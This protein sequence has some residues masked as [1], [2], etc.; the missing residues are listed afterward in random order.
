MVLRLYE[1]EKGRPRGQLRRSDEGEA[2]DRVAKVVGMTGRNLQRYFRLLLAPLE[3]QNAV[4]DGRLALVV[5]ERVSS[6]SKQQ[7]AQ[8]AER[9]RGGEEVKDVVSGYVASHN[10]RH[11]HATAGF[12]SFRK[13]LEAAL[14]DLEDRPDD[15]YR[16]EINESLPLLERGKRLLTALIREGKKKFVDISGLAEELKDMGSKCDGEN[17]FGEDE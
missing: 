16:R 10:G 2:R 13:H 8:I 7:Q 14:A 9:I 15:I 6:L 3:V 4:R 1:I 11:R 5:G 12:K 17:Y